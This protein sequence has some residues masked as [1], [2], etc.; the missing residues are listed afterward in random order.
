M[1]KQTF[2]T[3]LT[4]AFQ[5]ITSLFRATNNAAVTLEA[6]TRTTARGAIALEQ[7]ML[8]ESDWEIPMDLDITKVKRKTEASP[9]A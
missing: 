7:E 9:K 4:T 8:D 1:I 2:S 5:A 6:V 3:M